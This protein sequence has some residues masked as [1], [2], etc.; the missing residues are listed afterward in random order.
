[1]ADDESEVER[2][3]GIDMVPLASRMNGGGSQTTIL[4]FFATISSSRRASSSQARNSDPREST[5]AAF[6]AVDCTEN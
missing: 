4:R 3:A 6:A 5:V 1:M 2:K